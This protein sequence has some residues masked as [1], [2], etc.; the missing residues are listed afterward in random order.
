MR[1][2]YFLKFYLIFVASVFVILSLFH[3]MSF[4]KFIIFIMTSLMSPWVFKTFLRIKGVKK[5]DGVLVSNRRNN[6]MGNF[7]SKFPGISLQD[8][9]VGDIITVETAGVIQTGK[10]INMGGIIFPPEVMIDSQKGD[11]SEGVDY[12]DV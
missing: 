7:I 5:G 12:I 9:R 2:S 1:V 6:S 8:G 10:I 3:L 4:S 11:Y